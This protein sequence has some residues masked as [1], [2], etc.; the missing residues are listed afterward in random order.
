MKRQILAF[1]AFALVSVAGVAVVTAPSRANAPAP[2]ASR[3]ALQIDTAHSSLLFKIKHKD[4]AWFYGRFGDVKGTF[5]L[6]P[7]N[8][9][10]GSIEVTVKA[11][12]IDSGNQK[13]D[14]HLRS[15][16]FFSAKE[17]ETMTFK[18]TSVKKTGEHTFDVAGDFSLHGVT[19][20][21]T[22]PVEFTGK[23]SGQRGGDVAGIHTTF[24][25]KRSDYGMSY[26]QGGGLGDE[27]TIIASLE[28]GTPRQP[29][30]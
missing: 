20:Q 14:E 24:T 22:V 1:S 30:Q 16:D 23:A 26:M 4:V 10:G 7:A 9:A 25:I 5:D 8:A 19:K 12:S 27:V 13:R 18:S 3:A 2:A 6:D 11:E 29:R 17:F 21:I 28:G 15:P